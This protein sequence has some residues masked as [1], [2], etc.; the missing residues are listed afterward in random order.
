MNTTQVTHEHRFIDKGSTPLL[1]AKRNKR[2]VML[3]YILKKGHL[4]Y[5]WRGYGKRL[6]KVL[7]KKSNYVTIKT[8]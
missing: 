6:Y 4:S 8:I 3:N 1:D 5:L 2:K 7:Y